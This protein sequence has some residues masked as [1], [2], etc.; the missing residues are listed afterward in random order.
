MP[1]PL[2]FEGV[3]QLLVRVLFKIIS[4][5]NPTLK[6]LGFLPMMVAGNVRQHRDINSQMT[7]QFGTLRVLGSIRTDIKLAE[8][9]GSAKPVRDYAPKSR[10]AE[11]FATL[12][13]LLKTLME[14]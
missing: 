11:D 3:R 7:R 4:E 10:G 2:S 9:F 1:H 8:A 14:K 6:I 12:V 13:S 5:Q